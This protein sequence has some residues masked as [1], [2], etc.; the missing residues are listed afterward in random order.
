MPITEAKWCAV[1]Q[2]EWCAAGMPQPPRGHRWG[3]PWIDIG[4][5]SRAWY[6]LVRQKEWKLQR[7]KKKTQEKELIKEIVDIFFGNKKTY[8][9]LLNQ[10]GERDT[11]F[12]EKIKLISAYWSEHRLQ[13]AR[14]NGLANLFGRPGTNGTFDNNIMIHHIFPMIEY[15]TE[16]MKYQSTNPHIKLFVDI[17]KKLDFKNMYYTF[18]CDTGIITNKEVVNSPLKVKKD[19]SKWKIIGNTSV[20]V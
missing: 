14:A 12:D 1:T 20:R 17:M 3:A 8:V 2:A 6:R 16:T 9:D 11:T 13:S 15:D 4:G 7:E 19:D 10:R 18:N 5:G